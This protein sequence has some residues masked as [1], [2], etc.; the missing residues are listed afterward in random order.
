MK[1]STVKRG[2][3]KTILLHSFTLIFA[4]TSLFVF[5]IYLSAPRIINLNVLIT[6][7][8]FVLLFT[9]IFAPSWMYRGRFIIPE[10]NKTNYLII[11]LTA[12][13]VI[14]GILFGGFL[15]L[16][17][18]LGDFLEGVG[19]AVASIEFKE[20]TPQEQTNDWLFWIWI[21][22]FI[23]LLSMPTSKSN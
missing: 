11:S 21:M 12:W 9:I 14:V 3:T 8:L 13:L 6:I 2:L 4:A 16:M 7:A 23:I 20:K 17:H 5:L 10:G 18:G 22:L 19:T 15:D 1:K